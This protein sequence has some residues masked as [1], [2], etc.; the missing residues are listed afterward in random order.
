MFAQHDAS[1]ILNTTLTSSTMSSNLWNSCFEALELE[2]FNYLLLVLCCPHYSPRCSIQCSCSF[3]S[4]LCFFRV[5]IT[6]M[7]KRV[8]SLGNP[9]VL[10]IWIFWSHVSS[11]NSNWVRPGMWELPN[12]VFL[13]GGWWVFVGSLLWG[14]LRIFAMFFSE[15]GWLHVI[16]GN[17]WMM[18]G[19]WFLI[20]VTPLK[21]KIGFWI[22]GRV[23]SF[24]MV[25]LQG[26]C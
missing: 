21:I 24:G 10:Q 2:G 19:W 26:L 14:E 3:Q 23:I 20:L 11:L 22:I 13:D 4:R 18:G 1:H 12:A 7:P 16:Y 15:L 6:Q 8:F 5:Q 25:P 17:R 9:Q